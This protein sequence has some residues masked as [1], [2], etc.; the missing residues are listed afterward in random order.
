MLKSL[1]SDH[2]EGPKKTQK[3]HS[4]K[5]GK[6]CSF[7]LEAQDHLSQPVQNFQRLDILSIPGGFLE[8]FPDLW[9]FSV[10]LKVTNT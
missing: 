5:T 9:L 7:F 10:T 4:R 1:M 3:L 2:H 8:Y 6:H